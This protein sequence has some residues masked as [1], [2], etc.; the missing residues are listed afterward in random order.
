MESAGAVDQQRLGRA[1]NAGAAHL[2]I[3]D[4]G[5]G[6]VE[7]SRFVDIDVADAFEMG[8]DRHAG[9]RLHTPDKALAAAGNDDVEIALQAC[10]HFAD[11]GAVGDGYALDGILGQVGLLQARLQAGV[12]GT[13]GMDGVRAAAQDHGIARLEAERT[14]IGRHIR[15]AFIDHA[16]DAERRAHTFDVQA[17]RAVPFGND[18]ADRILQ[19][20]D[21]ADAIGHGGNAGGIKLQPVEHGG[22]Q[23]GCHA[24]FHVQ[25]IGREDGIGI[26][27]KRFG[28]GG[29]RGILGRSRG[30]G[31]RSRSS[32]RLAADRGHQHGDIVRGVGRGLHGRV[33]FRPLNTLWLT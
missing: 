11:G 33:P 32:T 16:D 23:P 7:I 19:V 2:G 9:F 26:G 13:G 31:Q 14:G 30:Y 8:E 20:S 12:D 25:R 15:A 1:A 18:F 3:G 10:Q 22:R 5:L 17:V 21:G 4:D 27:L 29:E 28:H 6:H 24:C